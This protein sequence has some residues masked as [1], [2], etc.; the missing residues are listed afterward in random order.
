VRWQ[1]A[2]GVLY[3]LCWAPDGKHLVTSSSEGKVFIYDV[4][5]GVV[6]RTIQTSKGVRAVLWFSFV[7]D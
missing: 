3:S 4:E 6:V 7:I 5:K 2:T 1:G